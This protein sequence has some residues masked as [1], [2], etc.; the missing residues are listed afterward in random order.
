M[1]ESERQH[2]HGRW[3]EILMVVTYYEFVAMVHRRSF[4]VIVKQLP[5]GERIFWS[6]IPF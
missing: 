1:T 4:K 2:R 3:E 5:R 6:L